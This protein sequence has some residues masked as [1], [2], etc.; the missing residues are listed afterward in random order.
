VGFAPT[1]KA[2]EIQLWVRYSEIPETLK[3]RDNAAL[4]CIISHWTEGIRNYLMKLLRFHE[5]VT[6]LGISTWA[7]DQLV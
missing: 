3:S 4:C 7:Q 1:P 2:G 5:L 6:S